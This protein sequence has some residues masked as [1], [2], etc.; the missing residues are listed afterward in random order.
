[1]GAALCLLSAACFGAMAIFGKLAYDAGVPPAALLLV[2]FSLAAV[3][4]GMMLLVRPG[5]RRRGPDLR[6]GDKPVRPMTRGRVLAIAVGLGAIGYA[7]QA[8]LFFSALELM[9][10]SL[11][12]LIL[13]TYPVMVTVA[14]VSLGR[15]RLT[16]TR[17]VALAAATVGTLLVLLGAGGVSFHPL[18]ALLAFAS[19]ITYTVYILV[20]DT[21][22]HRLAPVVLSV[23]VMTGAAGTLGVRALLTGGVDLDF[24]ASGW[25]WLACIA[26][27]STVVAMLTFFAGL[28]RTGP[29]TAAILSTFEPVV[30]AA[31]ATLILGESLTPVQLLGGT[32]VLSSVAV[33]Q[34]R[35]TRRAD[36]DPDRAE[37]EF[38]P[39]RERAVA[40]LNS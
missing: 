20:A 29:S 38:H 4:L 22:V 17:G 18:G 27:L 2:R 13:Y 10:A 40:T 8:S 15:D 37:P 25:V 39:G 16:P 31:L 34:L 30:T 1:M 21:V 24:G 23:L 26:V 14:A 19:A 5:L 9:D 7:T 6:G 28:K 36:P 11:L 35:R 3:L 32:L 33:L 12:A